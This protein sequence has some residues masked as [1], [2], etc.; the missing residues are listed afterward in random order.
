MRHQNR[1]TKVQMNPVRIIV[2]GE[3]AN[4]ARIDLWLK[5][6]ARNRDQLRA[7]LDQQG[8]AA[9]GVTD[10]I[11]G[12]QYADLRTKIVSHFQIQIR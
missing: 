4:S 8:Y 6:D 11:F 9:H 5:N 2:F 3:D 12:K 10:I 7:W 1:L